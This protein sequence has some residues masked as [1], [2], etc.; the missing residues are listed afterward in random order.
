[1][2]E[3]NTPMRE[4]KRK[5]NYLLPVAFA[6]ILVLSLGIAN[7]AAGAVKIGSVS[8]SGLAVASIVGIILNAVLP[9]KDY[10]FQKES[11]GSTSVNFKV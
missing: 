11:E 3:V 5:T 8:L 2:D 10:E 9:G 7:S 1:M 6:M 4:S